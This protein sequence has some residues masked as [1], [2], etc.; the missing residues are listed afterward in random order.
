MAVIDTNLSQESRD[1][2]LTYA[3]S[4]VSGRALPDV[5]DGLKPVQRRILFAMLQNLNLRPAGSH[6]KSAAVVGEVLAR[7][8]PHGDIACYEA[9]VRMTQDFSLR[10][11]LVDGQGNFGSLDGDNAAAY[12]YTEAKLRQLAIDVIGEIDEETVDFRDNFDGTVSEPVVLPSRVPNL[13]INGASGIAVGMAT[14]IPPHNLSDTIKALT[15]LLDEPEITN[16]RL[17]S[18]LKG[19]DFPTGCLILNTKKEITE[20]YETGRGAIR[21][22]GEWGIEEQARGKRSIVVTS[23]PYALNKAQLV[24]KIAGLIIDRKVPQLSDVRDEST[25][26]VRIVLELTAGADPDV[27]MAYL[28]KNTPLESAFNVNMTALVPGPNGSLRPEVLSLKACLQH[29]LDFRID[30]TRKRLTFERKKLL[31]RI[32]I[33]EGLVIIY[34][35]LDEALKIVRKSEG[36][37]DSA[38]K[39]RARF[40]LSEIQAYAVVDMKIYQL[41]RTN[42]LEIREELKAKQARVDEI[43]RLLKSPAKIRD[44]VRKDL[45]TIGST[46]GDKRRC[47][48]VRDNV[49][50]EFNAEDYV[51]HEDVFAIVT[52]DGWIKRI[53]QTNELS[54]TRLREGDSIKRA[55]PLST[56]DAVA[57]FTNHGTLYVLKVADFPAS[58]G[59]GDPVQKI[60]KFK[61]GETI[62]D[63][64]GVKAKASD[65]ALIPGH[66][67]REGDTLVLVSRQGVG[68]ALIIEGLESLK[69]SGKRAIKLR[70]GDALAGVCRLEG[71]V[72]FFTEKASGLIV[73]GKE[74]PQRNTAAVGVSLIGVRSDDRLVGV[75]S[76]NR[77]AKLAFKLS[78]GKQVEIPSSEICSGHR[79]LKGTKVVARGEIISVEKVGA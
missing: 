62:V 29:F 9:M 14:S 58:S 42:I 55:L 27:A 40:K 51:V 79:A 35:A 34:D 60:L 2:Y 1:R 44:L 13:L 10:Y 49:E 77:N 54:S 71:H 59:Y 7:F 48:L 76:F 41:S 12:R 69:R 74:I 78:T 24:E 68:F 72:G 52:T 36:R 46:Y 19:P 50:I 11:P 22:R 25:D 63:S 26:Q 67:I 28:F 3:L 30:V 75:V 6:R 31:E 57:F 32:H 4:V 38:E 21:M 17:A 23:I 39:L 47:K 37:A 18:T 53:R 64:F 65:P 56:T 8:H 43:D 33:L 61:D 70:D 16:A 5:R 73:P 45:E 15:E 20:I 66:E